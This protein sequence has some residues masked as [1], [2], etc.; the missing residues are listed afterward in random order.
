MFF[1]VLLTALSC[2]APFIVISDNVPNWV[3]ISAWV[4]MFGMLAVGIMALKAEQIIGWCDK[5][6]DKKNRGK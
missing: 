3:R 6:L 1:R 4:Y 5:Q 2:S